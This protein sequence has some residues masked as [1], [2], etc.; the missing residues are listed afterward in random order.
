MSEC[1]VHGK[2]SS[3]TCNACTTH[4]ML[5]LYDETKELKAR[6]ALLEAHILNAAEQHVKILREQEDKP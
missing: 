5:C 3:R 4:K 6:I 1:K 2:E